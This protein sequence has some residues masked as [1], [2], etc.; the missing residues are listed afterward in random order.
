MHRGSAI[1][2]ESTKIRSRVNLQ[3]STSFTT[4]TDGDDDN[5][6]VI[7][8]NDDDDYDLSY[9]SSRPNQQRL[10]A[11]RY[12]LDRP[13]YG[14]HN[15]AA[16]LWFHPPPICKP[17]HVRSYLKEHGIALPGL[18]V[19]VYLDK[20][21][22]FMALD[23][24]ERCMLEWDFSDTNVNEMGVLNVRLTDLV[25]AKDEEHM[26]EVQKQQLKLGVPSS[27]TKTTTATNSQGISFANVTP[28]GLFS[29]SLMVGLE[30]IQLTSELIPGSVNSAAYVMAWGPYMLFG[31]GLLQMLVAIFQV[32]RNN[33]Y[34]ATAFF[35]F[36][37]FWFSNGMIAILQT[38]VGVVDEEAELRPEDEWGY[39]LRG[40]FI[41]A[42][43]CALLV[44]TFAMNK[45]STTLI[46]LLC[47]KVL[48][49]AFTSWSR[50]AQ[51]L[52]FVVGWVTAFFAF[53]VFLVEF[54]NQIYHREVFR[55]FR[56][57]EEHSPEEVFGAAGRSGTLHSKAARLRQANSY[58]MQKVRRANQTHNG[59]DRSHRIVSE[60]VGVVR[61]GEAVEEN[62][63][64]L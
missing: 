50:V 39:F 49:S 16:R 6:S 56:W 5:N 28:V 64:R 20:I 36:G 22:S 43:C 26:T 61:G 27:A 52:Q 63:K 15:S 13:G 4:T 53:Y 41:L 12:F 29:F 60:R 9:P 33:V 37:S 58:N 30:T 44:Q 38:Y 21:E 32:M 7:N 62:V 10:V 40:L 8:A 11:V 51:W 19:E 57:S 1:L 14:L 42:F 48:T 25:E 2:S 47:I 17:H 46:S 59:S 35:G 34:G 55:V 23:A 45:L 18:L 31:G 3:E 54:T 24:C